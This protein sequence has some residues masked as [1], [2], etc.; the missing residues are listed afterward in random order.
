MVV[1]VASA[2]VVAVAALVGCAPSIQHHLPRGDWQVAAS[3]VVHGTELRYLTLVDTAYASPAAPA[4]SSANSQQRVLDLE[5]LQGAH[6]LLAL[7]RRDVLNGVH[8][9]RLC[10]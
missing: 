4:L 5:L 10:A 1:T 3:G 6:K 9:A 8:L 7:V 2:V